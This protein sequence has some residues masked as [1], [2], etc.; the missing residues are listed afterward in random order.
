MTTDAPTPQAT[1]SSDA[2][3]DVLIAG[4]GPT[5]M[6]L[7]IDLARRGHTVRVIDASDGSFDGSRA[8]GVQ[9]RTLEV[10]EDL[11]ALQ[12]VLE[13]GSTY[14]MLGA[15]LGPITVPWTMNK[16]RP[17]RPGVP[18]PNTWLIPQYRT[19][20]AL[21]A[22]AEKAGV[23]VDFSTR[24]TGLT[25]TDDLVTSTVQKTSTDTDSF[26]DVTVTARYLLGADGA[27]STVRKALGIPFTG[28]TDDADRVVL[29]DTETRGLARNRWHV[30][31]GLGKTFVGACPLPHTNT[32]Q[33]MIRLAP[34]ETPDL[35]HDALRARVAERIGRKVTLGAF[36]W[37][38]VFRPNIRLADAYR[39]GRVFVAGD[40]AH[41]HPPAGAQGL[42]T[43]IQDSY[44]LGWKL[45]QVLAGAPDTLLDS[46]ETERRPIAA[47]VLGLSS[48]KY[49]GLGTLDLSS[50]TRGDAEQQ[51]TLNYRHTTTPTTPGRK[52]AVLTGDRAPDAEL[53]DASGKPRRLFEVLRG[54][55]FT[56]I[57]FGVDT[58]S[59]VTGLFWP[60]A[61]AGLLRVVITPTGTGGPLSGDVEHV[62]DESG[63]FVDLYGATPGTLFLIRPDGYVAARTTSNQTPALIAAVAEL[64]P[65]V[66][67]SR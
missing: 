62:A 19:N 24:L 11:G 56:L 37:K 52:G 64:T 42:N 63:Q 46:Y 21:L 67:R 40:A 51:L 48:R 13:G 53:V 66:V 3:V 39:A 12:Q 32:F 7:A 55:H 8:K 22:C 43:G 54:P 49:D 28:R 33:W 29:F 15:H 17:V 47:A 1:P 58:L 31:P 41:V 50:I 5:G 9:P 10:L 14:P 60:T 25:Q 2:D 30:W 27:S 16:I 65:R 26:Q 57:G 23:T 36:A 6:T 45:S 44:N 38:S 61:G 34:D 18:Y 59:P 20:A 4:A 35:R